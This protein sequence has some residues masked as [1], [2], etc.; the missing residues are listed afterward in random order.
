MGS[1]M[2]LAIRLIRELVCC[3]ANELIIRRIR[4]RLAGWHAQTDPANVARLRILQLA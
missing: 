2:L 1:D 3:Y 4:R